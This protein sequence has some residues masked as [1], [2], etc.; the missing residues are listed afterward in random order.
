MERRKDNGVVTTKKR[1]KSNQFDMEKFFLFQKIYSNM[2]VE[3]KILKLF[4]TVSPMQSVQKFIY[5]E[6]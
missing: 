4:R 6:N 3:R 1:D 2:I 5:K